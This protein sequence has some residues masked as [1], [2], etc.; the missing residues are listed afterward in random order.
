MYLWALSRKCLGYLVS[1]RGIEANL[2][3]IKVIQHMSE[4]KSIK[5]VQ[6]LVGRMASL[7]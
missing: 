1:E 6:R 7:G 4:P 2:N 3:K 5:K